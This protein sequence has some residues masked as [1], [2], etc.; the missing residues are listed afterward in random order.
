[1]N[2]IRQIESLFSILL[3]SFETQINTLHVLSRHRTRSEI[4]HHTKIL[5]QA[6]VNSIETIEREFIDEIEEESEQV[7]GH[8][9]TLVS[10]LARARIEMPEMPVLRKLCKVANTGHGSLTTSLAEE[11]RRVT[12]E[13][14][15]RFALMKERVKTLLSQLEKM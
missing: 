13:V 12:A 7:L 9:A 2:H 3:A 5:V 1:M 14:A 10:A 4:V 11:E 8:S 15:E 6:L